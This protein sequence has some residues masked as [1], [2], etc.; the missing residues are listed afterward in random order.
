MHISIQIYTST[1]NHTMKMNHKESCFWKPV[2]WAVEV[3]GAYYIP[4]DNDKQGREDLRLRL[5]ISHW[6]ELWSPDT[7]GL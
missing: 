1:H 2:V 4:T 6:S 3:G 5:G 7:L